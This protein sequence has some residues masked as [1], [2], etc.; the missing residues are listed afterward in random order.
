MFKDIPPENLK[1]FNIIVFLVLPAISIMAFI[2]GTNIAVSLFNVKI[3][4]WGL[5]FIFFLL[6]VTYVRCVIFAYRKMKSK[7]K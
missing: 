1:K 7:E 2:L 5:L 3:D 4:I 6:L